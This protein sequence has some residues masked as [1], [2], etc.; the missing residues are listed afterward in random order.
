MA[1]GR[2]RPILALLRVLHLPEHSMS[3]LSW[4]LLLP[5]SMARLIPPDMQVSLAPAMCPV[6]LP[7]GLLHAWEAQKELPDAEKVGDTSGL[8]QLTGDGHDL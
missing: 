5:P 8:L 7:A 6:I 4:M 2:G 3:L 1:A